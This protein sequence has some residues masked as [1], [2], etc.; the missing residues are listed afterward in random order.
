MFTEARN[1]AGGAQRNISKLARQAITDQGGPEERLSGAEGASSVGTQTFDDWIDTQIYEFLASAGRLSEE[2][3][4]KESYVPR[5]RGKV[6]YILRKSG[7]PTDESI[8]GLVWKVGRK[9]LGER[10]GHYLVPS[11]PIDR[12]KAVE[13]LA[14]QRPRQACEGDDEAGEFYGDFK[15]EVLSKNA[16]A[17]PI[18]ALFEEDVDNVERLRGKNGR[19]DAA[20]IARRL[21]YTSHDA[22]EL[23]SYL[24]SA[25]ERYR[26]KLAKMNQLLSRPLRTLHDRLKKLA[27]ESAPALPPTELRAELFDL[28]RSLVACFDREVVVARGIRG[29]RRSD[30]DDTENLLLDEH[31]SRDA[32]HD[33]TVLGRLMQAAVHIREAL[34]D[35]DV[36]RMFAHVPLFVLDAARMQLAD[37]P[38]RPQILLAYTY[39]LRL[40]AQYDEYVLANRA[41]AG[42]CD[43]IVARTGGDVLD[44]APEFE[45]GD[46]LRRVKTKALLNELVGL[47]YFKFTTAAEKRF[48]VKDHDGLVSL[49]RRMQALM[50]FDPQAEAVAEE[51]VVIQAHLA[52]AAY[53]GYRIAKDETARE[54][55]KEERT[56]HRKDLRAVIRTHFFDTDRG[57]VDA[58]RLVEGV[59]DVGER[60]AIDR[61]LDI[62]EDLF[63]EQRAKDVVAALRAERQAA[64]PAPEEA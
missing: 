17:Y 19:F 59:L 7:M 3:N 20:R 62:I 45:R 51:L 2:L 50:E 41:I 29:L 36:N 1:C 47:F 64:V 58:R 49:P 22:R 38:A 6:S 23:A 39:T 24:N 12:A 10:S 46:S 44:S 25:V 53:N 56:R 32:G 48:L 5:V 60:A 43:G 34:E 33:R 52:R 4:V 16:A 40:T 54:R 55:W 28:S 37:G 30:F 15:S 26:K 14:A 61:A 21:G 13:E 11:V 27:T 9:T 57:C 63:R 42:I 31:K 18:L 35:G 8:A